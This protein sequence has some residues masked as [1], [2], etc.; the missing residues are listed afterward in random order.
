MS[1]ELFGALQTVVDAKFDWILVF[2]PTAENPDEPVDYL[3]SGS[4]TITLKSNFEGMNDGQVFSVRVYLDDLQYP[5]L[6]YVEE[7]TRGET[8]VFELPMN[9]G[10]D[11]GFYTI[12]FF[13][14]GQLV[15]E[16]GFGL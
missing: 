2:S 15:A 8:G 9:I 7:W 11:Y 6:R 4:Q 5:T 12:Q 10:E 14:D 3:D 13:V 16:G 1:L